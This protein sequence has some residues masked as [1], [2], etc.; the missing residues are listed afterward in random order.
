MKK[1]LIRTGVYE[2][3]SSSSHSLSIANETKEFV[4]DTI[5]PD[6]DGILT[7]ISAL[8]LKDDIRI[9]DSLLMRTSLVCCSAEVM[10]WCI[11]IP[12]NWVV[13]DAIFSPVCCTFFTL[14]RMSAVL[15]SLGWLSL[16]VSAATKAVSLLA[17][18]NA[19]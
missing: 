8:A 9:T 16:V 1:K 13:R 3:N 5:Y 14:K 17:P 6:Q 4:L 7:V 2:T 12:L 18:F 19:L 15:M 11:T 10:L